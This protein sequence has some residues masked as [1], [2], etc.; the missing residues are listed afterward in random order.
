MSGRLC[1]GGTLHRLTAGW[2]LL[3][4]GD[5]EVASNHL[6]QLQLAILPR[7]RPTTLYLTAQNCP[8]I[9]AQLLFFAA[10]LKM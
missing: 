5:I 8:L 9:E 10:T 6:A 1:A 3:L 7:S 2:K 4:L